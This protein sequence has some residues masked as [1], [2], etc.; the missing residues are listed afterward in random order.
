MALRPPQ[1]FCSAAVF[2]VLGFWMLPVDGEI[3]SRYN[4]FRKRKL[5]MNWEKRQ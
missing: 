2:C 5:K 1:G 3:N 4:T